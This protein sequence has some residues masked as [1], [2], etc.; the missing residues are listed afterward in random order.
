MIVQGG[1][2]GGA[3]RAFLARNPYCQA[4]RAKEITMPSAELDH[5]TPLAVGGPLWAESNWA[6]L[7]EKCHEA[8]TA[9]ENAGRHDAE[10]EGRSAWRARIDQLI[11]Q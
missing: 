8:K 1:A 5:V 11:N 2:T 6:A 3:R 9:Q 10:I 7:C 4:C